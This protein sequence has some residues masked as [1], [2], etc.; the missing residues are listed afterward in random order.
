MKVQKSANCDLC[1]YFIQF[2]F[3]CRAGNILSAL[4]TSSSFCATGLSFD[5]WS[6]SRFISFNFEVTLVKNLMIFFLLFSARFWKYSKIEFEQ[7]L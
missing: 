4:Y 5:L 7:L 2:I 3:S 6:F 1:G